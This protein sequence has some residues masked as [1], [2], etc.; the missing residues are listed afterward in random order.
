MYYSTKHGN[1]NWSRWGLGVNH[2]IIDYSNEEKLDV[3]KICSN[4]KRNLEP[5]FVLKFK[6]WF[7]YLQFLSLIHKEQT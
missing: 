2:W 1:W 6:D 4:H 3:C 5:T 7:K